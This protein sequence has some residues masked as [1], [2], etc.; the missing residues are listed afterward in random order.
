METTNYFKN[1]GD[2]KSLIDWDKVEIGARVVGKIRGRIF[3]GRIFKTDKDR[4]FCQNERDGHTAPNKLGFSYSW[5]FGDGI[6]EKLY[7]IQSI[8]PPEDDYE[9]PEDTIE[10]DGHPVNFHEYTITVGCTTVRNSTVFAIAERI[11]KLQEK[12]DAESDHSKHDNN[13]EMPA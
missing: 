2:L 4:W 12:L 7:E 1:D 10:I 6:D 5:R 8:M 13:K 9:I 3:S 11:K